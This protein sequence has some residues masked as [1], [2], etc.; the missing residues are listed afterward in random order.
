MIKL[1]PEGDLMLHSQETVAD[2]HYKEEGYCFF[3]FGDLNLSS[4]II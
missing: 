3:N 4:F 1:W 2:F